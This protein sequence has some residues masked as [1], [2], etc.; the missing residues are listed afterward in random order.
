MDKSSGKKRRRHPLVV[1]AAALVLLVIVAVPALWWI[2]QNQVTAAVVAAQHDAGREGITL[3]HDGLT[4]SGFPFTISA[5]LARPKADWQGGHWEGPEV[6][7]S[8]TSFTDPTSIRIDASGRH[9]LDIDALSLEVDSREALAFLEVGKQ[10]PEAL[11]ANLRQTEIQL[12]GGLGE[13]SLQ[14]LELTAAPLPPLADA[15]QTTALALDLTGLSLPQALGAQLPALGTSIEE[16]SLR[17][18]LSGPLAPGPAPQVLQYWRQNGGTLD[19]QRLTLTWGPVS[20]E[21]AGRLSL[22]DLLRPVG[23][24]NLQ[25]AG[26]PALL[27]GLAALGRLD[28]ALAKTYGGLLGGMAQPRSGMQGRWLALPLVLEDGHAFLR[29]PFGKIPLA[30]LQPLVPTG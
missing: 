13:A 22:D 23:T 2:A 30:K 1:G 26:F 28:P 21:A 17:A 14:S 12:T 16:G 5:A 24:L 18:N 4:F 19:L 9:A 8:E 25:A 10:G 15:S 20:L 29:L 3:D 7:T 6:L 11:Q 27:D